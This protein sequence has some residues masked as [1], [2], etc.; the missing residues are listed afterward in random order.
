MN[1]VPID[2]ET[3]GL[4]VNPAAGKLKEAATHRRPSA[5]TT[6]RRPQ[7]RRTHLTQRRR[8]HEPLRRR[9][10]QLPAEKRRDTPRLPAAAL[11]AKLHATFQ[12]ITNAPKT[13]TS[14]A[15]ESTPTSRPQRRS[16]PRGEA[17]YELRRDAGN[18][19]KKPNAQQ[20]RHP[21]GGAHIP[22]TTYLRGRK[23]AEGLHR[24]EI[25]RHTDQNNPVHAPR[26]GQVTLILKE[27]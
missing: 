18:C 11:A 16:T 19:S 6:P 21:T 8:Q 23:T 15:L 22:P 13:P 25:Y 5:S 12:N 2:A 3:L 9:R 7:K 24:T 27:I 20:T 14:P 10:P 17:L 26:L 4:E 1:V